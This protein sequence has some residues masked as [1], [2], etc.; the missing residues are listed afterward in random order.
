[1]RPY[2]RDDVL[3]LS[4]GQKG[5]YGIFKNGVVVYVGSGD[6]REKMLAHINGDNP[7]IARKM[8][9]QWTGYPVPGD[10]TIHEAQLISEFRPECNR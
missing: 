6:V 8:P 3:S 1:M 2:T 10:E 5:V 7:C 9:N 4:F